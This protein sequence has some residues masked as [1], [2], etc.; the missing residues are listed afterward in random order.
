MTGIT[1]HIKEVS[2]W[3]D[4]NVVS[5]PTPRTITLANF[6]IDWSQLSGRFYV[7]L[8]D[9][10]IEDP[11]RLSLAQNGW[12]QFHPPMFTSPLGAPASYSTVELSNDTG[13]AINNALRSI[14]P[15]FKPMGLDAASG[16]LIGQRTPIDD[17]IIDRNTF[18]DLRIKLDSA[19]DN[20]CVAT[21]VARNGDRY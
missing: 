12:V 1:E 4:E 18:N 9:Q 5:Y 20:F 11:F 21:S 17:R 14:F 8:D 3:L 16:A 19:V 6:E 13:E 7:S 15:R 2:R 10:F